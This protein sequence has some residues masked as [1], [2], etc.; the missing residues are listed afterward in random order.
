MGIGS[1]KNPRTPRMHSFSTRELKIGPE[2][3]ETIVQAE[4]TICPYGRWFKNPIRKRKGPCFQCCW[5]G[6]AKLTGTI[7][8]GSSLR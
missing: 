5:S 2:I 7:I 3:H 1:M 6:E 8:Q 4:I